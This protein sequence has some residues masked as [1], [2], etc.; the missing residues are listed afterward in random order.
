[1]KNLPVILVVD[2][3]PLLQRVAEESLG[4]GGFETVLAASGEKAIEL[5]D[6]ANGRYRALVTDIKFRAW[7][8][9]GLGCRA[10]CPRNR[11]ALSG[12]L[13]ERGKRRRLGCA[14]RAGQHHAGKTIR[15]GATRHRSLPGSQQGAACRLTVRSRKENPARWCKGQGKFSLVRR[16]SAQSQ[17]RQPSHIRALLG[18]GT[19]AVFGPRISRCRY[20]RCIA[21][22]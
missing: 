6:T 9:A 20:P 17:Q 3:D 14:G 18:S 7:P 15:A 4:D 21:S 1:L 22:L 11:C 19:I 2:D 12:C 5:L 16:G 10:P 8:D 13:Y